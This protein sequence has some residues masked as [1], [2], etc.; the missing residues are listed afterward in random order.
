MEPAT[1]GRVLIHSSLG[2]IEVE[3]WTRESPL[4]CKNFLTLALEGYYDGTLFH[5]IS[6]DFALQGGDREHGDG[7]GGTSIFADPRKEFP[8]ELNSRLRFTARGILA[9]T[10]DTGQGNSSQ[11]FITLAQ[12][13]RIER[14]KHTIF[15][16]VVGETIYNVAK[17][18]EFEVEP[19]TERPLFP[20]TIDRIEVLENPFPDV[21]PRDGEWWPLC[22]SFFQCVSQVLTYIL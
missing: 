20:P 3:L 7:T 9:T 18:N 2:P 15:G 14:S 13:V 12:N 4:A 8:N 17:A 22:I 21:R 16:R 5:R 11:F 6:K 1:G 10:G 19:E